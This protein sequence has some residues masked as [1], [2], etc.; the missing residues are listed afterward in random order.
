[1]QD[2]YNSLEIINLIKVFI[3]L[4][5][6]VKGKQNFKDFRLVRPTNNFINGQ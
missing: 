4:L 3:S 2:I 5:F 6:N 1:M